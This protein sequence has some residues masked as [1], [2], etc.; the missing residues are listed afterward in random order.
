MCVERAIM[1]VERAIMF[2]YQL[3]HLARWF[4][5]CVWATKHVAFACCPETMELQRTKRNIF[6]F[7]YCLASVFISVTLTLVHSVLIFIQIINKVNRTEEV[8]LYICKK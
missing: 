5:D 3:V 7:I 4:G 8:R 1:C 6:R 2:T